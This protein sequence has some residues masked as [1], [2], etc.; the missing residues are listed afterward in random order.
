MAN[1]MQLPKFLSLITII[2]SGVTEI[3]VGP[4]QVE[5]FM[6]QQYYL[7]TKTNKESKS[8]S[9]SASDGIHRRLIS[10]HQLHIVPGPKHFILET[11]TT[12][13][14]NEITQQD[15]D[16]D[17]IDQF[18]FL[19]VPI[20]LLITAVLGI[21][22]QSLINSMLKGDQG[23]SAFLSDG[24]GYGKSKFK[25]R[26]SSSGGDGSGAPLSGGDPLPWLKLPKFSY[27]DVA[28]QETISAKERE[29]VAARL[30]ELALRGKEELEMGEKEL[31]EETMNEMKALMEQCGFE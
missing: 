31:A 20:I 2:F 17:S 25:P 3:R 13:S 22:S 29:I 21:S 6:Q 23:L 4:A 28:G 16:V 11:T 14:T 1:Y 10:E 12:I 15:L 7:T 18:Q 19:S 27:V 9:L 5:A 30:E 24:S 8:I 26:S